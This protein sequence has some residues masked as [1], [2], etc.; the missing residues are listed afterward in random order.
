MVYHDVT[1][2][3]AFSY[4]NLF[5]ADISTHRLRFHLK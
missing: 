2:N 1:L 3:R 5:I 4:A